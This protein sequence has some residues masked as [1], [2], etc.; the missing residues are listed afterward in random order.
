[1]DDVDE[2]Q[3]NIN[4][5]ELIECPLCCDM[6]CEP[7]A[8]PCGHTFCRVCLMKTLSRAAKKCPICRANCHLNPGLQ[9]PNFI[10]ANL[11]KSVCPDKYEARLE[12]TKAE[13]EKLKR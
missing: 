13:V 11:C 5:Q 7:I 4:V 9:T 6:F 12:E 3:I 1:M 2:K 10:I 8:L